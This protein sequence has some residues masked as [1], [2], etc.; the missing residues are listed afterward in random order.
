M[1]DPSPKAEVI[2]SVQRRRR[3]SAAEKVRMVEETYAPG[4]SVRS[5]ACQHG[6]ELNQLFSWH[7]LAAAG[8]GR[9][10][11]STCLP[12]S[13]RRCC[14]RFANS[15]ARWAKTLEAEI[16]RRPCNRSNPRKG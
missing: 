1:A 15:T 4:A 13:T 8:D 11:A 16:S 6:V 5:V 9:S 2:I 7:G 12:P 10:S 14:S 3:W